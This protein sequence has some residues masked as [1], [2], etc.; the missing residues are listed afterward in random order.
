MALI[1]EVEVSYF[2]SFTKGRLRKQKDLNIIFGK[3][4][5]GKSNLVRALSLFFNGCPDN[6]NNFDFEV[7]FSHLRALEAERSADVRKF[8]YVKI[9]F[10]TP[11]N[12]QRSLGT[13][14]SV[15][16]QWTVSRGSDYHEEMTGVEKSKKHIVT[17][18]LNKIKFTYVPAIKDTSIFESLLNDIYS[19]MAES[20]GFQG[21]LTE[22]T[23][24]IQ[25]ETQ[26]LFDG[27]PN[28]VSL[29]SQIAAPTEVSELFKKLDFETETDSSGRKKSL[30]RQRGDGIKARHIPELL[31]FIS[32]K[33]QYDFHVWGFEE[34]ENS[35]DYVSCAAE[36]ESFLRIA[37]DKGV[38][39]FV[40]TH[41]PAFYL[42]DDNKHISKSYVKLGPE[43]N[44]EIIQGKELDNV[45]LEDSME[46]GFYLP[47]VAERL[48]E[49]EELRQLRD[50]NKK[51]IAEFEER[52]CH[53]EKPCIFTEGKTDTIILQKAFKKLFGDEEMPFEIKPCQTH[54]IDHDGG[55]GGASMLSTVLRGVRSDSLHKVL[56]LFDF[57]MEGIKAYKLDRNFTINQIRGH[58]YKENKAGNTFAFLLPIPEFRSDHEEVQNCPIEFLFPD[59]ILKKAEERNI[60][61]LPQMERFQKFGE[62][63]VK[64]VLPEEM[65]FCEIRGNK[66]EFA[67]NFIGRY[68]QSYFIAFQKL[69]QVAAEVLDV[70]LPP[71]Q[72]DV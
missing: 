34:P 26:E 11:K 20:P 58:E 43:G 4:D 54:D 67:R 22:F 10:N 60:L 15:K 23:Q 27:L 29:T 33:D 56:G 36:A 31:G 42:L 66:I 17:R 30:T 21:A 24:S 18:L 72:D 44:S 41:N 69:F 7:D 52:I 51:R 9:T 39:I 38:Q 40:T 62:K 47:A 48:S 45:S 32:N 12:F 28:E 64:V 70:V 3:N 35:L 46:D 2:R 13:K 1:D 55:N 8:L 16:R 5:A 50:E 53:I 14:F 19:T 57:D 61:K 25:H 63:D 65:R 71:M 68:H 37:K 6:L 59:G 49:I